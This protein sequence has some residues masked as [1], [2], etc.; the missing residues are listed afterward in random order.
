M[1]ITWYAILSFLL[2]GFILLEGFDIGAGM[3]LCVVGKTDAE[4]RGVIAAI[5][6]LL[7]W[8]EVWLVSFGGS[9]LLAFPAVLASS[10][11]GFYLALCLLLWMLLLRGI[12][13]EVSG[14]VDDPLWR[15]AWNTCFVASNMVLAILIGTALGNILRGVPIG[16]EGTFALPLFTNFSPR[17]DVGILDWYTLSTA[18]F[19]LIA[20]A[21]HGATVLMRKTDGPVNAR[22]ARLALLFWKFAIITLVIVTVESFFVDVDLITRPLVKPSGW[23][24]LAGIVFGLVNLARGLRERRATQAGIGSYALIAGLMIVGATAI[25]PF[26]LRS[27]IS[28]QYSLSA[29][30]A[31]AD[32]H[33]L[34]IGLVWWPFAM[35]LSLACFWF[36][37]RNYERN[38][39]RSLTETRP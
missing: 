21:A 32:R 26:M 27:T 17:R 22:C 6:P 34:A 10:F 25:F 12:S 28:P 37:Y 30:N 19:I 15:T 29:Y 5:G 14:H 38:P 39:I 11:A 7:S 1:I 31:A 13:I 20:F 24:G 9:L 2:T 3:L 33:G 36:I 4:R 8:N 35:L 18:V 23:L 16:A